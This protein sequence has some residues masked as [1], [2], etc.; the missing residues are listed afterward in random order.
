[1]DPVPSQVRPVHTLTSCFI[2]IPSGLF[3][4]GFQTKMLYAF[5]VST[6]TTFPTHLI[7]HDSGI[8]TIFGAEYEYKARDYEVFGLCPSFG[9]LKNT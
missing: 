9:I 5:L 7:V 1:L 4:S 3:S 6:S 2:N 8:L